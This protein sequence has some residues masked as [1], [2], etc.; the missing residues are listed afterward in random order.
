MG[1]W[2]CFTG[3]DTKARRLG[4]HT[5][6]GTQL[7]LDPAQLHR[8]GS[9][10]TGKRLPLHPPKTCTAAS[11]AKVSPEPGPE[12]SGTPDPEVASTAA[13]VSQECPLPG[14]L[15]IPGA[16]PTAASQSLAPCGGIPL[17]KHQ[18]VA[19][20]QHLRP[21][22]HAASQA[23]LHAALSAPSPNSPCHLCEPP[24]PLA[25]FP[26]APGVPEEQREG[27]ATM[28]VLG[29]PPAAHVRPASRPR[30]H[31]G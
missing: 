22:G 13:Q 16:P 10:V 23:H 7:E 27:P 4:G 12:C 11:K 8:G 9:L 6:S 14:L 15:R 2:A 1:P 30:A 28:S 17:S 3:Q 26:R 25:H 20:A 18:A 21:E 24:R 31:S 29:P 19:G 5:R